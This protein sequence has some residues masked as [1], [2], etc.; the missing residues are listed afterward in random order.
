MNKKNRFHVILIKPSKYDDEGY[1]IRWWR[2][3]VTS[4]S[5]SCLNAL[6]K[7]AAAREIL[8][9]DTEI[10]IHLFDGAVEKIPV[11]KLG[12]KI[13][14]AGEKGVVAMAGVQSNQFPRAFNLAME[15]KN[16][17]LPS[18]IGGFHV[19]GTVA[20]FAE[21][22]PEIRKALGEK[23]TLVAGEVEPHWDRLLQDAYRGDLKPLYDFLPEKPALEGTPAPFVTRHDLRH[24]INTQTSFDAGRGCPFQCSFCTIINVQGR[25]LRGRSVEDIEKIVR[26]NHGQKIK[27]F[28]ITDDNFARHPQWEA[29]ADR[30]IELKEKEGLRSSIMIQTDV[31]AHKIP[32]FIEKLARAGCR[33]VF[34]GM[35]SV[36]PENLAA[37][38]KR[39][40]IVREYRKMLQA[41]RD[42]GVITCAGYIVGFPN[43]TYESIMRDVEFLKK[44]IPL[45]VAEFFI[46]TPLPG[47]EDHKKLIEKGCDLNPDLNL[48]DTAHV[49][50]KHPRMTPEE[51]IRAYRDAWAS[52]YSREHSLTLLKR[53][54]GPRR[55]LL[56]SSLLWFRSTSL[57]ENV[58]PLLGGYFRI[59]GR[60]ARRPGMPKEAF[61]PYYW[62]RLTEISRYSTGMIK[63]F[64]ETWQL[65]REA[66]H[67][68]NADYTDIAITPEAPADESNS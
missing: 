14:A 35:E 22:P 50:M 46:W 48:Y 3:V 26:M 12:R 59:K 55:R 8:G 63:L 47:S 2:A 20:M 5:L 53:R 19:S 44:E 15:F 28:F 60:N 25:T 51:L 17:G 36:N 42:H 33:R 56:F 16:E 7:D 24:F 29:I 9:A 68:R 45:D 43:D 4:N 30:L 57:L 64:W 23:I 65:F 13:R 61:F 32:R 52:F 6:T 67:P 66:Q 27:K 18:M 34:I 1:V 31:L 10:V 58:H 11:R 21:H 37:C 62:R 41:W 38:G 49:V 54:K 40:N 39:Q